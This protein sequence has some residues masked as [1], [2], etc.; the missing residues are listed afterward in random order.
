MYGDN[1]KC[2]YF[3]NHLVPEAQH[4]M[5]SLIPR[6]QSLKMAQL[7]P[8]PLSPTYNKTM[9]RQNNIIFIRNQT[10]NFVNHPRPTLVI[11]MHT[12]D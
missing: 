5:V 10:V 3:I 1:D 8:P 2:S 4:R 11:I 7:I 9:R 12:I 6:A